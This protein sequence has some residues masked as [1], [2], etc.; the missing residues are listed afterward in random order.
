MFLIDF[1]GRNVGE[2][3]SIDKGFHP[4]LTGKITSPSIEGK[5]GLKSGAQH[6]RGQ[7]S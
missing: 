6:H 1:H 5:S 4:N 2:N 3:R 7:A